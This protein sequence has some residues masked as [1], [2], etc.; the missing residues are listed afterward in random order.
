[1]FVLVAA[2]MAAFMVSDEELLTLFSDENLNSPGVMWTWR[3]GTSVTWPVFMWLMLRP[4]VH[5]GDSAHLH[6]LVETPI[7][8]ALH[9][10][11]G[12]CITLSLER[13]L[14]LARIDVYADMFSFFKLPLIVMLLGALPLCVYAWGFVALYGAAR[15]RL[16]GNDKHVWASRSLRSTA[17]G[18]CAIGIPLIVFMYKVLVSVEWAMSMTQAE[19][20]NYAT[21]ALSTI[22]LLTGSFVGE[23]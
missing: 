3:I 5:T 1:M 6:A 10:G 12:L 8:V 17:F 18:L 9:A 14:A 22:A 16:A 15:D 7:Y 11:I 20:P 23:W 4:Y 2:I 21:N 13:S 19:M